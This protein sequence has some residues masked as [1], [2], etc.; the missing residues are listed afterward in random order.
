MLFHILCF[1]Y[2]PYPYFESNCLL[3][4]IE[5]LPIQP[6]FKRQSLNFKLQATIRSTGGLVWSPA[7]AA[8]AE[9]PQNAR[10]A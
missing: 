6:S 3:Y 10:N 9:N 8:S 7:P 2:I 5:N 4:L 1:I